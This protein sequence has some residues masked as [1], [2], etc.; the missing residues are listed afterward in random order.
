MDTE[1]LEKFSRN[2]G[3]EIAQI[4]IEEHNSV[5]FEIVSREIEQQIYEIATSYSKIFFFEAR[6]FLEDSVREA[7][8]THLASRFDE[9]YVQK[10]KDIDLVAHWIKSE[11]VRALESKNITLL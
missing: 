7:V 9:K 8:K 1:S 4:L 2:K 5:D 10:M 11:V 6:T 3:L